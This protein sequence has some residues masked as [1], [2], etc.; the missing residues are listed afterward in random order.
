MMLLNKI[1]AARLTRG[2]WMRELALVGGL[3]VAFLTVLLVVVLGA[4]T[5]VDRQLASQ[6]QAIPWG[7]LAFIPRLGSDLGGGTYGFYL[8]PALAATTLGALRRW[9]LLA[10]LLGV[11]ALHYL[12]ISPKLFITAYRPSPEFGVQGAGGLESFPSGHVQWAVSFYGFLAYLGWRVAPQRLRL[13]LVLTY[14]T[15]VLATILGRIELGR[16]WP[17]DTLAGVLVGLIALRILVVLHAW[18]HPAAPV[19]PTTA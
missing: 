6:I 18:L 9:R 14:A 13:P 2:A 10:L 12:L 1:D 16:H 15:V 3:G 11:F 8:V 5:S 4:P 7:R 17:L 19:E